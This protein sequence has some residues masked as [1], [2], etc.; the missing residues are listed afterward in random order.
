M[1]CSPLADSRFQ[2]GVTVMGF[3]EHFGPCMA[4]MSH[5]LNFS[6]CIHIYLA[7]FIVAVHSTEFRVV[8][9]T[10]FE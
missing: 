4:C 7:E 1:G 9:K 8:F 5:S 2:M 6:L 3:E 10:T